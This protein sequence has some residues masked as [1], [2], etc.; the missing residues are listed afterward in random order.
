MASMLAY[1]TTRHQTLGGVKIGGGVRP[2]ERLIVRGSRSTIIY[3]CSFGSLRDLQTSI[4][5]ACGLAAHLAYASA[6]RLNSHISHPIRPLFWDHH[7][8]AGV[9]ILEASKSNLR[10]ARRPWHG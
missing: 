5:S 7:G 1:H 8:N 9:L 4:P 2:C 6:E 3:R 10:S